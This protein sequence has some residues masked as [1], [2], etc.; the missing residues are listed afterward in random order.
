MNCLVLGHSGTAG[1]GLESAA[2][3]WPA[4]L[5]HLLNTADRRGWTVASAPLFPVGDRAIDYALRRIEA[6]QPDLVV[7]S[8]NAYPC[9][10]PVVSAS[11]RH[12]FGIRAERF[13]SRLERKVER[14]AGQG[15]GQ[16]T[17]TFMVARR[18]T[19]R[20]LGTRTIAQ[21]GEVGHV[22]TGILRRLAQLEGIQVVAVAE[23]P[24]GDSVRERIP[25][26]GD[27]VATL[28]RLVRQTADDHRFLW[29]DASTWLVADG[30]GS[31]WHSDDVH[32]SAR[33]NARY[34]EMLAAALER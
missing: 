27:Q 12:R 16:Q 1:F 17:K 30:G 8:V 18:G 3:T 20:L 10:V 2:Q 33:G 23:A 13:Y 25:N 34:A 24:F 6:L 15:H 14:R 11:V 4:I 7:L 21:V 22:Y 5:E 32:L 9:V 29:F 28:Q 31:F 26:L 19:R